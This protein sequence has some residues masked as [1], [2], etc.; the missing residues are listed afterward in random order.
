MCYDLFA[1]GA[2]AYASAIVIILTIVVIGGLLIKHAIDEAHYEEWV[3]TVE[4]EE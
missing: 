4:E 2:T 3:C 1:A